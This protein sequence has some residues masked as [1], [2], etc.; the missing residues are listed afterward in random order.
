MTDYSL[1]IVSPPVESD[2]VTRAQAFAHAAHDAGHRITNVFFYGAGVYNANSLQRPASD[3]INS[4]EGWKAL[5]VKTGCELL[6]C[7]TAALKRGMLSNEEAQQHGTQS[8]TV[9]TPFRQSGL[10]DFFTALHE[11]NALVQF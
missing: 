8:Y 6:V 2:A 11:C 10:G 7:V 3:E 9:E 4:Y 5:Q 1:L